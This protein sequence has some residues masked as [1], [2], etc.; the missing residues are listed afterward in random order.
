MIV[1]TMQIGKLADQ[2]GVNVQTVRFYE[3]QGLLNTPQRKDSG[4]R[5]YSEEDLKRLC[6]IRHAKSLGFLLKEI[7]EILQMRESGECP[8]SGVLDMA[9]RHLDEIEL[10]IQQLTRFQDKLRRAVKQ[11]KRSGKQ[12]LSAGAFCALIEST[13]DAAGKAESIR[14]SADLTKR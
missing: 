10:Q 5:I 1:R 2:A 13:M 11:W 6:F 9:E 14:R 8:C 4:Y 12:T 3:R 7:S